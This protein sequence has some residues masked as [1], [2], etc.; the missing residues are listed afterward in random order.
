MGCSYITDE[1][2]VK[3]AQEAVR[4]ELEKC[5]ALDVPITVYD[6]DRKEIVVKNSDG[7]VIAVLERLKKDATVN[8]L[9]K[10]KSSETVYGRVTGG[11]LS[12]RNQKCKENEICRYRF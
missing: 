11:E 10:R 9:S 1:Q 6:R 3:R 2:V 12:L 4:L 8:G 5:R 7:T